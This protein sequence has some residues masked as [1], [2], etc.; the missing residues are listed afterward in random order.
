MKHL[1]QSLV[2]CTFALLITQSAHSAALPTDTKTL[3]IVYTE[4][5]P[6]TYTTANGESKGYFVNLI[7]ELLQERNMPH[8]FSA[9][10]TP[11]IH[12]QLKSGEADIYLGPQDIPNLQQHIWTVPIPDIFAIQLL[13]WR[14]PSTPHTPLLAALNNHSLAVINGFGYGGVLQ[15]L[16]AQKNKVHIIRSNSHGNALKMLISGRAD[17]L[18][19]YLQPVNIEL[20]KHPNTE[21][22]KHPLLKIKVAFMISRHIKNSRELFESLGAA[23]EQHYRTPHAPSQK[24]TN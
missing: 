4:F 3:K 2:I 8:T 17:Y 15:Q 23:V 7:S 13:L 10:P 18:L 24:K 19:D 16:D 12:F 6:Y 20:A 5:P 21:L 9:H 22:L 11:R 14:K 1:W